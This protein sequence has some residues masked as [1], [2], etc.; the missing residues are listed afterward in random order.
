M[1]IK[2]SVEKRV[3]WIKNLLQSSGAKGII[4][5]NSGG[6]DCT[7]V[8]ALCKLATDNVLGVIMPCQSAQNYGSDRDDA[9]LAGER[10]GIPQIQI[11]L[12]EAK[13]AILSALGDELSNDCASEY[14]LKMAGVNI[15]P[16]LRMTALYALGQARGY[17]VAGTGNLDE[18][19]LGYFTKW[20]DG[21]HDFNPIADLTVEEVYAHLRYLDAP[22]SIVDKAPSA[23]LYQGQTDEEELGVKYAEVDAYLKG[24]NVSDEARQKIEKAKRASAHKLRMPLKFGE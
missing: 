18:I 1:D 10:F 13:G 24:E 14:N 11:D 12:S 2:T 20:G 4:Y 3:E 19:T 23:G 8:G 21:A 9:I 15:N 7:L 6:K 5:G 22:S 17:L 16:R